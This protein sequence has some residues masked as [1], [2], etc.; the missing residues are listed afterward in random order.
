MQGRGRV[1]SRRWS[2]WDCVLGAGGRELIRL[3]AQQMRLI[4]REPFSDVELEAFR[5]VV[6]ANAIQSMQVRPP[7]TPLSSLTHPQVVLRGFDD[8]EIP[9]PPSLQSLSSFILS[10]DD[11]QLEQHSRFLHPQI[12]EAI[13]LLWQDPSTREVVRQSNRLQLND[14]A[15]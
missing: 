6:F 7:L 11:E 9:L 5:A 3:L 13:R 12:G 8:L 10:L 1:A 4:Y 15:S 14:S 2:R